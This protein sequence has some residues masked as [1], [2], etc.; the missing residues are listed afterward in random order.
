VKPRFPIFLLML[1][2]LSA[3]VS[4]S[5]MLRRIESAAPGLQLGDVLYSNAEFGMCVYME[6]ATV[7]LR[8][9]PSGVDHVDSLGSEWFVVESI[10][11][12][13]NAKGVA[14]ISSVLV[15]GKRCAPN[16]ARLYEMT[17]LPGYLS[18]DSVSSALLFLPKDATLPL[19][20]IGGD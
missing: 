19:F 9:Q 13:A 4:R 6:V 12:Y 17:D 2:G 16:V 11:A 7:G 18:Y 15:D 3:C 8:K 14:D 1:L 20:Y 5:E 10:A